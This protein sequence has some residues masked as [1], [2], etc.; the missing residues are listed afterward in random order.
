[1]E[2]T[3]ETSGLVEANAA[4]KEERTYANL[5]KTSDKH[6]EVEYSAAIPNE[7]IE[8]Y[9]GHVLAHA[10]EG[11]VLPGFRKG[12]VPLDMVRARMDEMA[13]LEDAADEALRA[14][15]REIL[16]D[17]KLSLVGAPQLTIT[18]IALK[19]PIEFKVRFALYPAIKLPDY[20]KV[21]A[22]VLAKAEKEGAPDV[23][24]VELDEAVKRLLEMVGGGTA[25]TATLGAD[26]APAASQPAPAELTDEMVQKFGPFKTV[27]DFKIKLKENL[28]QDKAVQAKE[29]RREE[30]MQAI[31]KAADADIPKMLIDQEWY[32]FEERR[33]EELEEAKLSLADYVKQMG[34][35]EAQLEK[36]ER[37]LI[38][39]RVKTSMVFREIQKTENITAPEKEI[40]TNIAYLKLRYPDRGETWLRETSEALIIQG[41]IFAMLGL[42]IEA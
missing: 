40:Q 23:T 36:D 30:I 1:M 19:N 20:K 29:M 25:P 8:T 15:V 33:N 10:A 27:A 42:P 12:K 16:V 26:G 17:E 38:E 39:E 28:A 41:K 18:K 21:A 37:A 31:V 13:L 14:A 24:E 2:N 6:G 32:A 22:D 4:K 34:K 9:I 5:K 3:T 11:V 35:T 7:V